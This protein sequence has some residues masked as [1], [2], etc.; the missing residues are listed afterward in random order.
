MI[1]C[2]QGSVIGMQNYAIKQ[3][4]VEDDSGLF[5]RLLIDNARQFSMF[6]VGKIFSSRQSEIS[7]PKG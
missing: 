4:G 1:T 5:I 6:F 3:D 7:I 2:D